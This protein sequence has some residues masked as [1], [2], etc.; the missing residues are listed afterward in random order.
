MQQQEGASGRELHDGA[1]NV[2]VVRLERL[3]GLGPRHAGLRH[4]E[5]DVAGLYPCLVHLFLLVGRRRRRR[6]RLGHHLA[7][8]LHPEL[9]RGLRLQLGAQVLDLGLPE[10]DVRLRRRALEDVRLGHH[11]Q[12]ILGSLDGN[13]ADSRDGFHSELHHG[14]AA[15]L[16]APAL[17]GALVSDCTLF[18]FNSRSFK[19]ASQAINLAI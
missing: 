13:P 9:L 4:D 2:A 19:T 12:Y 15:L 14:L 6:V 8:V 16:L 10:Y 18:T 7:Q 5:V 17:L 3:D 1:H 11:E